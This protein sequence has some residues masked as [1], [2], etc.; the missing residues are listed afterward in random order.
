MVGLLAGPGLAGDWVR[1]EV[2]PT[3][4]DQAAY[5]AGDILGGEQVITSVQRFIRAVPRKIGAGAVLRQMIVVDQDKQDS[6][7]E[8][9]FFRANPAGTYTDQAAEA[10]T[11]ADSLLEIGR[12]SVV[13]GDYF[14]M[15]NY[16][17]AIKSPN[18]YLLPDGDDVYYLVRLSDAPTY[19]TTSS[20]KFIFVLDRE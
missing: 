16:S 1:R 14:G 7:F 18:L 3:I 19:T 11:A 12:I 13:S 2:T 5:T 4:D 6:G 8:M 9:I 17:V 20:L 10:I 15:T